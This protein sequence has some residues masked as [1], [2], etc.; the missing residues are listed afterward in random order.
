[1]VE[2]SS[3][4]YA[5]G[6]V[7]LLRSPLVKPSKSE[8]SPDEDSSIVYALN[9]VCLPVTTHLKVRTDWFCVVCTDNSIHVYAHH[10]IPSRFTVCTRCNTRTVRNDLFPLGWQLWHPWYMVCLCTVFIGVFV[11][12]MLPGASW[13]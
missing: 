12:G 1:M 11:P 7:R 13:I 6:M 2:E 8:L 10:V 4:E 3:L 5:P 9:G